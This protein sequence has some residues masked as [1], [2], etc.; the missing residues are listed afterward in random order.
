[1]TCPR[2]TQ[3]AHPIPAPPTSHPSATLIAPQRWTPNHRVL[4][5]RDAE[6]AQRRHDVQAT[7][8]LDLR[9]GVKERG[10]AREGGKRSVAGRRWY[11]ESS[12]ALGT[13][14]RKDGPYWNSKCIERLRKRWTLVESG[15]EW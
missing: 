15:G 4:H 8:V 1:M 6:H 2:P 7:A 3:G 12:S 10:Q 14:R 9:A 5:V 13:L 11:C